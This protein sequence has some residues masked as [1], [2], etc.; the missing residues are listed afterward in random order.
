MIETRI[1]KPHKV[2]IV[3]ERAQLGWDEEHAKL[4]NIAE[5]ERRRDHYDVYLIV[6]YKGGEH[7][8]CLN[9]G[10][11][12]MQPGGRI[13]EIEKPIIDIEVR[14]IDCVDENAPLP[15]AKNAEIK[16]LQLR[17]SEKGLQILGEDGQQL[18][19]R[20]QKLDALR[21]NLENFSDQV[22][23]FRQWIATRPRKTHIC[24][25]CDRESEQA[26]LCIPCVTDGWYLDEANIL[27]LDDQGISGELSGGMD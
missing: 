1:S 23:E 22:D 19:G 14:D 4:R 11:E 2:K 15:A 5:S 12:Y 10:I 24:L 17:F 16:P 18:A 27:C 21:K 26:Q 25:A 9:Y 7:K 8:V 3:F 6:A 20:E 13:Q